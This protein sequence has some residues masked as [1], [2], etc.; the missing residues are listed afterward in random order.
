ML[1][2][3]SLPARLRFGDADKTLT[4]VIEEIRKKLDLEIQSHFWGGRGLS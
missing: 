1:T 3:F 2:K 4:V